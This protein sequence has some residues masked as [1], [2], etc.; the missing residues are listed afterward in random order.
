MIG[1]VV[2]LQFKKNT[3]EISQVFLNFAIFDPFRP[4]FSIQFFYQI[5]SW[6]CLII[7][8]KFQSDWNCSFFTISKNTTK[9]FI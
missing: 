8:V 7:Y 4:N 6:F 2:F 1:L 5:V 9:K 3:E